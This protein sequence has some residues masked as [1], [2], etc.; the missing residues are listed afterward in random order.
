MDDNNPVGID[1]GTSATKM[2][3]T[4]LTPLR[5]LKRVLIYLPIIPNLVM[6]NRKIFFFGCPDSLQ[7]S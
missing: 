1:L 6:Y 5:W 3:F 2:R 7:E 4:S